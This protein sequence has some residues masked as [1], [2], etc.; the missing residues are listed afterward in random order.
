[1]EKIVVKKCLTKQLEETRVVAA[2]GRGNAQVGQVLEPASLL[3][4]CL[5]C[6]LLGKALPLT[7]GPTARLVSLPP[8]RH[9]FGADSDRMMYWNNGPL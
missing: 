9:F 3:I 2:H 7:T 8:K 1:M 5:I 4:C 6:V